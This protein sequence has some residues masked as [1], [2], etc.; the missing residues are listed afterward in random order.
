VQALPLGQLV[1]LVVTSSALQVQ[2]PLQP[3]ALISWHEASHLPEQVQ[4]VPPHVHSPDL[5]HEQA[6]FPSQA[7]FPASQQVQSQF[8]L[9]EAAAFMLEG[10]LP[11]L[12]QPEQLP[13]V[14]KVDG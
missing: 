8:P 9:H 5:Q 13:A 4:A 11:L 12:G 2:A 14:T 6:H 3:Q 7:H 10:H 1:A